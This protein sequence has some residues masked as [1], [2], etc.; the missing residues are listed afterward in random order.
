MLRAIKG[1]CGAS[2]LL[3]GSTV[4]AFAVLRLRSELPEL[5]RRRDV[6]ALMAAGLT[7]E[8]CAAFLRAFPT[9]A[10]ADGLQQAYRLAARGL[11]TSL[12]R[13]AM[14]AWGDAAESRLDRDAY[15]SVF[16]LRGR[17]QDA[18]ALTRQSVQSRLAG[19]ARWML[20][21]AA[22]LAGHTALPLPDVV[23]RVAK[24]EGATVDEV[25]DALAVAV[26]RGC[27][28]LAGVGDGEMLADPSTAEKEAF[29]ATDIKK[30]LAG[31][32]TGANGTD[33]TDDHFEDTQLLTDQ[34]LRAVRLVLDS[35]LSLLTGGPG[36][37]K[38]T[39]VRHLVRRL[40]RAC[41]LTAPTGRAARNVGGDTVHR[42]SAVSGA[43]AV[44][45]GR[46]RLLARR[47]LQETRGC[48]V[49]VDLT[50]LVVDEASM[51]DLDLMVAVLRLAPP[52]CRVVLVGDADQLPPVG[53]GNVFRDL[54]DSGAVPVARLDRNYRS[55][56]AIQRA[57]ADVLR[58]Q[59]PDTVPGCH[60]AV[61]LLH[62]PDAA[63][64]LRTCV[65][66]AVRRGAQVLTPHN[67]H[68]AR[69]NRAIQSARFPGCA[70]VSRQGAAGLG[71]P[72]ASACMLSTDAET[73]MSRLSFSDP[74]TRRPAVLDLRV[75]D[76]LTVT[77]PA[78]G[79]DLVVGDAVMVLK[80]VTSTTQRG[81]DTGA[82][83]GRAAC[84]GDVGVLTHVGADG[85]CTV[86]FGYGEGTASFPRADGWLTLAYAATVHKFQGSECDVV[87]LP[88]AGN[89]A[90]WDRGLLYTA[91]TRARQQ[92]VMVGTPAD[93]AAVLAKVRPSRRSAL[94]A[95]LRGSAAATTTTTTPSSGPAA[96]TA[97]RR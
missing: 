22:R 32:C 94:G 26:S 68:R 43:G 12:I 51:L 45:G 62:A 86:D 15:G 76:A 87:A 80:N 64:A 73:G 69:L 13:P 85:R 74:E 1:W 25:R 14:D 58:G 36:S 31:R 65:K 55:V 96:T 82:C 29:V 93:L 5:L 46:Q 23:R 75:D 30:R 19:R 50:L 54:A 67:A 97:T 52:R 48:D 33:G 8:H 42:V 90:A 63:A 16:Q 34:Q 59:V 40:G 60:A 21:D 20:M 7:R 79:K 83:R 84:N 9:P 53:P 41:M 18:H 77:S 37:G 56:D 39:V 49:P 88:L 2:Q 66:L 11:T 91:L 17:V 92:A 47:P 35:P 95:L 78:P 38:S 61:K 24:E 3:P 89:V 6:K 44:G 72:P 81:S 27:L 57:A 10:D 70:V 4:L 71:I 28:T